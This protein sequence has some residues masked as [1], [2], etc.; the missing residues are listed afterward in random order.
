[1]NALKRTKRT[2][3][4]F[5]L[6]ILAFALGNS[7]FGAEKAEPAAP[8]APPCLADRWFYASFGCDSD[9]RADELIALIRRA[10]DSGFNG[11]LWACGV[12]NYFNWDD[13]RKARL[14]KIRRAAEDAD[15]EIIPILWSI[16]YGT[17]LGIDPN[18]AEGV[19]VRD[20]PLTV[21]DGF[22]AAEQTPLDVS[23]ASF[24]DWNGDQPTETVFVDSKGKIAF[25][26]DAVA[27]TGKSSLRFE[28]YETNPHGHGRVLK[29]IELP[30]NRLYRVSL[31]L[32]AENVEGRTMLAVHSEKG[33]ISNARPDFKKADENGWTK[34]S[35]TFL[36]PSEGKTR[37]YAGIWDGKTGRFWLDDM[38]LEP[39]GLVNPLRREGTPIAVYD[40]ER[41]IEYREGRDWRLPENYRPS[42]WK[43]DAPS[44]KLTIPRGSRIKDGATLSV[45]Y[46]YPPLVGAPQIGTCMSTKAI[47]RYFEKSAKSVKKALAPKK[48]FLSMDEIRCAGTC[49]A[50]RERG[51]SLAEIL[52]DCLT[53]QYETIQ[54]TSPGAEVYVWS[55]M[56]D[57]KHNAR[58]DYYACEGD[59]TGVWDLVPKELIISCWYYEIRDDSMKFFSER[60]F[61]TQGAA[62]YDV[63]S[64]DTSADWLETCAKT[65]GCV[66]MMYTTWRGK[67]ELLDGFG[68]MVG[69]SPLPKSVETKSK[70]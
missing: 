52:G 39:L 38:S 3:F 18:L 27:R 10:A 4:A 70:K 26:D 34:V 19:P 56:L 66:G 62:Y 30:P 64:L 22:A 59:Y 11:M 48:W 69:E 36:S 28:N 40:A 33:E 17:A 65:P 50:C 1:M 54:K 37:I 2:I 23:N 32:R 7:A 6:A 21:A 14:A 44:Q 41:K 60:G 53:R 15:V 55:D 31:W 9:A 5:F 51:I 24:E 42:P 63:D 57:P 25:R 45:D 43:Q 49:A 8:L 47:Y 29:E 12:E 46:Y 20:L 61:R 16:G 58:A 35:T 13:A 67:Y 68:K